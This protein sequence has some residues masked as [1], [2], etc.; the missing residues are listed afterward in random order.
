MRINRILLATLLCLFYS[1]Q[2]EDDI[3]I[4]DEL[5]YPVHFTSEIETVTN[6]MRTKA[7]NASWEA[8]DKIGVFMKKQGSTLSNQSILDGYSNVV[9]KTSGNGVFTP[10]GSQEIL[11]PEDGS[12]VDFIAYYPHRSNIGNYIYQVDVTDQSVPGNIDLL[13]SNNITGVSLSNAAT[14]LTFSHQL[15]RISLNITAGDNIS[16][17]DGLQVSV[18]GLR[19][20]AGFD[21]ATGTLSADGASTG[22]INLKTTA[23]SS[24]AL[25]EAILIPDEGG[26][27]RIVTFQLPSVGSFKWEIP[28]GTQLKKGW[29]YTYDITLKANGVIVTP[30]YGWT[31]TPIMSSTLP[32]NLTYVTHMVPTNTKIRNYAMLYDTTNKL[33]Y[34]VAYPLHGYYIGSS[35]R[36]DAWGYD[37]ELSQAFQARL[38][39][40][41]GGGGYDRGHQ[42]PSADRTRD[43]TTNST[44]FYYSNM[45]PQN[46]TLNQGIWATLENDMRGWLSTCD[47]LYVVTG[48]SITT[49]TDT[50][51]TYIKDNGG[52]N[53]AVPK[54]Y[55]K[56][57]ARKKG[58]N[59][60]TIAFRMDNV[61]PGSGKSYNSFRITVRQLEQETGYTFF[62]SIPAAAKNDN[63]QW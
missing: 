55:Y 3:V 18:S 2:D 37:P 59:Y 24:T 8:N 25:T 51:I 22:N 39:S 57:L 31:E 6:G 32:S 46:S 10:D 40:G 48:A 27:G 36:T 54:Y 17:L 15:S 21:L 16:S 9:Y 58:N 7:A 49:A 5:S 42:I 44:T 11:F 62:P 28:A 53:V 52:A 33:A 43:K 34:W 47:T 4:N 13:Y 63:V 1:C 56:A 35:G 61:A 45:T 38:S 41:Y 20:L 12:G 23:N 60:T 50:N 30:N 14:S 29:K 26:A 19:T